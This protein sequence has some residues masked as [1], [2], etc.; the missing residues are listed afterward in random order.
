MLRTRSAP[1]AALVLLALLGLFLADF[2]AAE[3]LEPE[4][5]DHFATAIRPLLMQTCGDCHHPEDDENVVRFLEATAR[6]AMDDD[7]ELWHSVAE[8]LRNRTMPPADA[9][10]PSEADRLM[11][12]DWIDRT[13]RETA[14][15]DGPFAGITVARRLNRVEYENTIRDLFGLTLGFDDTLPADGSGGEGFDNNGETLYL[16]PMLFE[17]YVAASQQILDKAIVSPP[18]DRAFSA[19]ELIPNVSGDVRTVPTKSEAAAVFSIYEDGPV[20][21]RI[22]LAKPLPTSGT[23]V[24]KVDGL[25]VRRIAAAEL[26]ESIELSS[27]LGRGMHA[28][29]VRAIGDAVHVERIA[30]RQPGREPQDWEIRKHRRLLGVEPGATPDDPEAAARERVA[31]LMR[32]AFRRSVSDEE[33]E[34]YVGL[35]RR[36][37]ERGDPWE[38]A[39]KLAMRP[40]LLSPHFLFRRDLSPSEE[41][42]MQLLDQH[43]L[44]SRLSYFLT[45]SP[46]DEKLLAAADNGTLHD[47]QTLRE[48]T[49]RLLRSSRSWSFDEQFAGQWL[50]TREVGGR[51]VPD[52]A[53]FKGEYS[54]HLI[55]SM[56]IE[57]PKFFGHVRQ[58]GRPILELLT[59]DYSVL[60]QHLRDHYGLTEN[61]KPEAK[62]KYRQDDPLDD[63]W[64]VSSF[65]DGDRGGLLGMAGVHL[66]TS[67]PDRT[68][69]VLRGA[70]VLETLLGIRVPNPPPNIPDLKKF[71]KG[72]PLS[73]RQQLA[74]HRADPT[75]AACHNLMDPVGFAMERFDPL[76]RE[77]K[78]ETIKIKG[79]DPAKLPID[80]TATLPDGTEF[81]GL[82]G[83]RTTLLARKG[84]F[85]RHLTRQM[86]GFA[87]S[88]SLDGRDDC[89]IDEIADAISDDAATIDDLIHAVVQSVPFRYRQAEPADAVASRD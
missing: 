69:P 23:V 89:T 20:T 1:S 4:A 8:Q 18:I 27:Q 50:G 15:V 17:R 82:D 16:Q 30:V 77:R 88:R 78:H 7:R 81:D 63:T 46:P 74:K 41:G 43:A 73:V 67:H 28:V 22:D 70:W 86:L 71:A 39:V 58:G 14:C 42:P 5:T 65:E 48:H 56:R 47:R 33:I 76:G 53:T 35:Y 24:V 40:V 31:G 45:L 64:H 85:K 19:A 75:C 29:A 10:Q 55:N 51:K 3:T 80:T 37:I 11:L 38:E 57:I 6:G 79:K 32:R 21:M 60:N 68:S 52:T 2:A 9:E 49:D 26:G 36:A 25:A 54:A 61:R 59:A 13:L 44:A 66:L 83:L 62:W 34:R 12:A 87:L 72:K 84:E